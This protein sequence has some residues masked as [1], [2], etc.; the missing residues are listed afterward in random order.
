MDG[1]NNHRAHAREETKLNARLS[2]GGA[3]YHCAVE[4]ISPGGAKVKSSAQIDTGEHVDLDLT[5]FG[6][7]AAHTVWARKGHLGLKFDADPM[8][9]TEIV[10]AIAM[11]GAG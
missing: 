11:Q 5:P 2:C 4:D 8:E 3:E 1:A 7:V 10:M 6:V 9:T